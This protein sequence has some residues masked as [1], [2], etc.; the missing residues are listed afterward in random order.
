M[1]P[2]LGTYTLTFLDQSFEV[3]MKVDMTAFVTLTE[4]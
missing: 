3:E 2:H 1:V 4:K